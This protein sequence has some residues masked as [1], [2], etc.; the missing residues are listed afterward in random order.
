MVVPGTVEKELKIDVLHEAEIVV[1]TSLY[2]RDLTRFLV[3]TRW[4]IDWKFV[5]VLMS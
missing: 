3:N 4:V 5:P 1:L 2:G